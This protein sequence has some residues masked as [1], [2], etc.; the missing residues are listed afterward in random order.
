LGQ[1]RLINGKFIYNNAFAGI[2]ITDEIHLYG[3]FANTNL[4]MSR[5]T[6]SYIAGL[7]YVPYKGVILGLRGEIGKTTYFF[8]GEDETLTTNQIVANAKILLLPYFEIIPEYRW[9]DTEEFHSLR[10]VLQMHLYY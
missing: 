9:L 10:W 1:A 2:A 5:Y 7:N 4:P 3:K 6:S 8:T